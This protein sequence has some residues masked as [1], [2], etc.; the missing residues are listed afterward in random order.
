MRG[1]M[2]AFCLFCSLLG[3]LFG[4]ADTSAQTDTLTLHADQESYRLGKF[5]E[6]LEDD[7]AAWTIDD[8]AAEPLWHKFSPVNAG[9]L[10][11][12]LSESAFWIRFTVRSDLDL[13]KNRPWFLKVGR[14]ALTDCKLFIPE[15]PAEDFLNPNGWR[16]LDGKKTFALDHQK[17]IFPMPIVFPLSASMTHE[18]T[19]YLRIYNPDGGMYLPLWIV[20]EDALRV[21]LME[22]TLWLGIYY[23]TMLALLFFNVYL[24]ISL[25][26][27]MQLYYIFYI[28]SVILYF[29]FIN[30]MLLSYFRDIMLY[31]RLNI[32][33]L[34]M[35]IFWG[36]YFAKSFLNT[37]KFIKPLNWLLSGIIIAAAGI[38]VMTPFANMLFLN[39][40]ASLLGM[41]SPFFIIL[42]G[43]MRWRRG[44]RPIV[45]FLVAWAILCIGGLIY[46]L[47]YRGTLPYS[48]PTFYSF[49]I[50][51]CLEVVILS[52][53]LGERIR[54][55]RHERDSIRRI[56]GKYVSDEVC[57]EIL[58]GSIPLDGE[59]KD[60]T[61]LISDL[62]DYTP[63]VESTPPKE[64]VRMTNIYF[65]AMVYGIEKNKG[66]VIQYVGDSIQAVFGAPLPVENH[67]ELAVRAALEMR[68]Q[69][70]QVNERLASEGY[71]RLRHG[72]GIHSGK[73][74]AANIGSPDRL[75]YSLSGL[76]VNLASRIQALNK[77]FGTDI[78]VSA[79]T[80]SQIRTGIKAES[81]GPTP[82]R[83]LKE[84]LEIFKV[85]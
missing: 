32:L 3:G 5:L 64:L 23:G 22:K 65:E 27:N 76:A 55:L 50:G 21:S 29:L 61:V 82:I 10:N 47:T 62:R 84:P 20:T 37:R 14:S 31:D 80:M 18:T 66:L 43:I 9:T 33:A 48:V 59:S 69:L 72:I 58:S 60:V 28:C 36:T 12:G 6:I 11:L 51:S 2:R 67:P 17:S 79:T 75:S 7:A 40:S 83:G 46:A 73:V 63:L 68:R 42:A 45:F 54:S 13:Q 26:E 81:L 77:Q 85:M 53:A 56:F 1:K 70:N 38:M 41:M 44:F 4:P 49:Q 34:A 78:L 71:R 35:T 74:T 25:R 57:D 15:Y 24:Y 39:E 16:T 30:G 19:Y 8:V 52:F